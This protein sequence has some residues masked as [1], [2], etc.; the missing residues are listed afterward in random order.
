VYPVLRRHFVSANVD[1]DHCCSCCAMF[2]VRSTR[3]KVE[4]STEC[5]RDVRSI[6]FQLARADHR[7]TD[8]RHYLSRWCQSCR[9]DRSSRRSDSRI[10]QRASECRCSRSGVV[11]QRT[12]SCVRSITFQRKITSFVIFCKLSYHYC[13]S[14]LTI[15]ARVC[16]DDKRKQRREVCY[17]VA[18]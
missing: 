7:K 4:T 1:N 3:S 10:F 13:L 2:I 6:S 17:C 16:T 8:C 12:H 14:E 15:M 18:R 11:S 9:V 5:D